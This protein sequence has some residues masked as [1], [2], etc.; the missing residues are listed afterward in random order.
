MTLVLDLDKG[1]VSSEQDHMWH[2]EHRTQKVTVQRR[3][4][5][6]FGVSR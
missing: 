3:E 1:Q 5:E 2:R 4:K 6:A